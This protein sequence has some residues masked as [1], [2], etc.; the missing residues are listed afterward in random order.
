MERSETSFSLSLEYEN[1]VNMPA[2]AFF[3]CCVGKKDIGFSLC[4]PLVCMYIG[5]FPDLY[6]Q[7]QL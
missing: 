6:N 1:N 3:V 7:K 5:V 4:K 2:D